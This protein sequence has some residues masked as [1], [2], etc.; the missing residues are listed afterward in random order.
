[1]A[2][3]AIIEQPTSNSL[4]AA[5]RPVLLTAVDESAVTPAVLYCDIYFNGIFY[6]TISK[7]AFRKKE[8]ERSEWVFDIQ[9]AAQ[10]FLKPFLAQNGSPEIIFA[11]GPLLRAFCR[12][13]TS[14]YDS[15]GF[16]IPEGVVPVQATGS[17]PATAGTGFE[18]NAFFVLNAVL[19]HEDNQN[20]AANLTTYRTGTWANNCLP[21]TRRPNQVINQDQS[22]Y[23]PV[24]LPDD[25]CLG[26]LQ[27]HYRPINSSEY[28]VASANITEV[29]TDTITS[30]TVKQLPISTNVLVTW[31][32]VGATNFFQYRVDGGVWLQVTGKSVTINNLS[33]GIHNIEVEP[34]CSCATGT[35]LIKS[36]TVMPLSSL[37]NSVVT[38]G[39]ITQTGNRQVTIQFSSTGSATNFRYRINGGSNVLTSA[40][41]IVLDDLGF[42]E[43]TI[44]IEPVCSDQQI[45]QGDEQQFTVVNQSG[46]QIYSYQV[47]LS[48]QAQAHCSESATTVYST[49]ATFETGMVLYPNEDLNQPVLGFNFVSDT[50]FTAGP[51]YILDSST[52][53]VGNQTEF[54]C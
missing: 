20:L 37:C 22:D 52:G 49:S 2:I 43:F 24:L 8:G 48:N 42:G 21:A 23:F 11:Q 36:F 16:I 51:I 32:S 40:T 33:P 5:Y 46:P 35:G 39:S 15:N 10:E 13:R 18:S 27:L 12:F 1:M 14:N 9:D 3:T 44:V 29:C 47:R 4:H 53:T 41:T 17:N 30:I 19:Q 34:V 54:I 6:R 45:G 31:V 25:I 26:T 38:I 28:L 50:G 7:T